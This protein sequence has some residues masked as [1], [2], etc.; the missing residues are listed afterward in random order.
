MLYRTL[1]IDQLMQLNRPQLELVLRL[2]QQELDGTIALLT[3]EEGARKDEA[4]L[5]DLSNLLTLRKVFRLRLQDLLDAQGEPA[6]PPVPLPALA[7]A[8]YAA[9]E[10]AGL[11][12]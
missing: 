3:Q 2:V 1:T 9:N 4:T 12:A 7:S 10:V 11:V 6:A 8:Q 5:E